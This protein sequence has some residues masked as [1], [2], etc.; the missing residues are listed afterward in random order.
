MGTLTTQKHKVWILNPSTARRPKAKKKAQEVYL[1]EE[2]TTKPT[3]CTKS[4]KP[5]KKHKKSQT[6]N[7]P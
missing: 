2:K 7:S 4:G 3:N 6:Q 1:E 5:K